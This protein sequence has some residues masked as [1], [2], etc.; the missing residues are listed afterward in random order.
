MDSQIRLKKAHL[1]SEKA[2]NFLE[3][4]DY[5]YPNTESRKKWLPRVDFG[6]QRV[7]K[8]RQAANFFALLWWMQA[9]GHLC[10]ATV[11]T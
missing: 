11:L 3:Q 1:S 8:P 4:K 6:W 5:A 9:L 7:R 2:N 10:S